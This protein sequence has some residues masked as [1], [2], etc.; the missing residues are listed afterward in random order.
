ME[1][2]WNDKQQI[3]YELAL[4]ILSS[5]AGLLRRIS[6]KM[7]D[8][9]VDKVEIKKIKTRATEIKHERKYFNGFDDEKVANVINL[10][11]KLMSDFKIEYQSEEV[12]VEKGIAS[13]YLTTK[14]F[15]NE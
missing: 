10:Y 4:D 7:M 14:A 2:T 5:Y 15:P 1:N 9:E 8:M 12:A 11:S 13:K 3:Q 6:H